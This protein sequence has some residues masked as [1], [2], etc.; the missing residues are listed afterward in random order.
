MLSAYRRLLELERRSYP[1]A[2][3]TFRSSVRSGLKGAIR[4]PDKAVRILATHPASLA[5][6]GQLVHVQGISESVKKQLFDTFSHLVK[7]TP[8]VDEADLWRRAKEEEAKHAPAS[9]K[10]RPLQ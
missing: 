2:S 1:H 3:P 8:G 5:V 9:P 7:S 4:A 10:Q 6:L